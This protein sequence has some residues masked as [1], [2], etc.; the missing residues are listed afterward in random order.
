MSIA[1]QLA[2]TSAFF[3]HRCSHPRLVRPHTR[4]GLCGQTRV[5]TNSAKV[6]HGHNP[7]GIDRLEYWHG[8]QL[9]FPPKI[10]RIIAR[11]IH[12]IQ[13]VRRTGVGHCADILG[14]WRVFVS[15]ALRPNWSAD[16]IEYIVIL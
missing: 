16:T 2:S 13:G 8:C 1:R 9:P 4:G 3:A 12:R 15:A 7:Q 6:S 5:P 10:G 11:M 14:V